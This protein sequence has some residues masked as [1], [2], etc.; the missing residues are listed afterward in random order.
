MSYSL[1]QINSQDLSNQISLKTD[2][3]DVPLEFKIEI[4]YSFNKLKLNN[5]NSNILLILQ[6]SFFNKDSVN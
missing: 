1:L 6:L 5:L 4:L 2:E 3:N